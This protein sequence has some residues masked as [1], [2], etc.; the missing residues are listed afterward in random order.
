[1]S[2][3]KDQAGHGQQAHSD[4]VIDHTG[5]GGDDAPTGG[6]NDQ[7]TPAGVIDHTGDADEGDEEEGDEGGGTPNP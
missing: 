1:M 2:E 7:P 6:P 3:Q 4:G 5:N